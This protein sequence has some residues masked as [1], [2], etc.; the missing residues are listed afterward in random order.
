MD[1]GAYFIPNQMNFSNPRP[2]V[3]MVHQGEAKLLR[4]REDFDTIVK[5]DRVAEAP[6]SGLYFP[7]ATS[8]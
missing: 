1:A 5:L 8:S 7:Q 3:V 6:P 2:A 4:S